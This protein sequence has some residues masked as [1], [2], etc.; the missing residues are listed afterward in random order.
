MRFQVLTATSMKFAV[1]CGVARI[2]SSG[3]YDGDSEHV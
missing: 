3:F 2:V 1:F